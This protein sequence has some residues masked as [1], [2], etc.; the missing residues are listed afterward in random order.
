LVSADTSKSVEKALA[1]HNTPA[2]TIRCALPAGKLPQAL[3]Q[4][5]L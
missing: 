5:V 1:G 2:T 3:F 4:S